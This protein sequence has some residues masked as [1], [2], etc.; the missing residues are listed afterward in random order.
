MLSVILLINEYDDDNDDDDTVQKAQG[1]VIS[2]GIG[3]KFGRIV[4]HVNMHCLTESDFYD[5]ITYI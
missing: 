3:M 4:L 5:K 1:S 2:N